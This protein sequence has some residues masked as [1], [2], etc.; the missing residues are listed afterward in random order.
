MTDACTGRNTV[1][2]APTRILCATVFSGL[3]LLNTSYLP[4][5]VGGRQVLKPS[6]PADRGCGHHTAWFRHD[7]RICRT[8]S[9][10]VRGKAGACM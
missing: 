6:L 7:R 1:A 2:G 4:S 5:I 3:S 8:S 9:Q 10:N